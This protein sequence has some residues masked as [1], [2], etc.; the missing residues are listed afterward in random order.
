MI[1]KRD[2]CGASDLI[3][4]AEFC[5]CRLAYVLPNCRQIIITDDSKED[6]Q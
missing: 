2:G 6:M 5:G 1:E 3:K 4:V